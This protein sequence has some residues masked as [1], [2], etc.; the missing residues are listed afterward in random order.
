MA[1][2]DYWPFRRTFATVGSNPPYK[3]DE[4]RSYGE[5]VIKRLRLQQKYGIGKDF[6]KPIVQKKDT[7]PCKGLTEEECNQK[8][9][10]C[11]YKKGDKTYFEKKRSCSE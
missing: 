4:P 2:R 5:G 11:T 8:L 3:K 9:E 6:E 7:N 1:L 10:D